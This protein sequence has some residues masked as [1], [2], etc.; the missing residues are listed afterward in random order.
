MWFPT[1][2]SRLNVAKALLIVASAAALAACQQH[3]AGLDGADTMTTASTGPA[4]FQGTAQLGT[5][6]QADPTNVSKG[7]AYANGLATLGQTDQELQVLSQL[8]HSH[9]DNQKLAIMFGKKLVEAGKSSEAIPILE[10]ASASA[11]ADWRV[12]SALGSAYDQQSLFDKAQAEY[13]KALTMQP[14]ELSVLNNMGMSFALQGNLKKAEQTLRQAMA[15]P[16]AASQPRI[17]QNLALVVG[18]QGN[19]EDARRIASE[20]LPADQVQ[21][22]LDY[23][24]KMLAQP[25]TWQQLSK[26]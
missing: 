12:H 5:V 10:Q 23:L 16:N 4:S 18:L 20:D 1:V 6:W 11:D 14:N 15:L 19:F 13:A 25:N 21:A 24:K 3:A 8:N 9:P 17:R 22:N 26:G 2:R 7:L